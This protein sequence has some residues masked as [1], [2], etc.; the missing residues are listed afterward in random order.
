MIGSTISHDQI[1]NKFG[2]GRRR[3]YLSHPRCEFLRQASSK[4]PPDALNHDA[5]QLAHIKRQ[6]EF[7]LLKELERG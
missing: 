4:T 5:E 7:W 1:R 3:R 6:A 2:E